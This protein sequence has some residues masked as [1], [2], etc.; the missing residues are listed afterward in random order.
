MQEEPVT[1]P[2]KAFLTEL[3]NNGADK[4]GDGNISYPE[5]E[6][7]T[8]I[9]LPPS[10]ITDL[11]GLEAFLNLDSLTITLNPLKDIDISANTRLSYLDI[12]YCGLSG[13][14][15][16]GNPELETL[17]CARNKLTRLDLS[18]NPDL[19]TL[20]CNNN[21]LADLDLSS[22]KSLNTII[23]CG[24]QL[25][26]LD[27]SEQTQLKKI[28]VD[29][30]PMLTELCVWILPFPPEGV[31]VLRGYSPNIQYTTDCSR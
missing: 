21:L 7:L 28:G 22:L 9:V 29:N 10:G 25:T 4:N 1:I 31:K 24:N 19:F 13:L 14:E 8:R 26:C 15:L 2:D 5:A 30:M 18:G 12:T 16:S 27:I 17:I 20:V 23:S 3:C 11:T 6:A